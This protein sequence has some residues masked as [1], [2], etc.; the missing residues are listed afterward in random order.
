PYLSLSGT[1]QATP[2]VTGTVALMLHA[3]PTLT[4]NAVKAILQYTAQPY[5]GYDALAQGVGFLNAGGAIELARFFA[6]P[7]DNPQLSRSEWS[8]QLIWGN[9]R[10]WGGYLTPDANAWSSQVEWGDTR[11]PGG[12]D[13]EWGLAWSPAPIGS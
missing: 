12:D 5:A 2:V 1:S 4:P 11:M 10:I 8:H 9:R 7:S 13:I 3:N 6:A